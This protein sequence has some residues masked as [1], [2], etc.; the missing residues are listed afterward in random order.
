VKLPAPRI[1]SQFSL[2]KAIKQRRSVRGYADTSLILA[3]LSQLL[4]AAQGITSEAG[5]RAAPSAGAT[6]P[7]EVYAVVGAVAGL[8]A[9]SYRYGCKNHE[10]APVNVGDQRRALSA[11]A[12]GQ[13]MIEDAPL[14]L[15]LTAIYSRTSR[16]YG[17]RASRYVAMEAE[18]ISEN[19]YLQAA[20]LGLGTVAAGAFDDLEVARVLGADKEEAPLYL[21]P[22]GKLI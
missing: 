13:S 14:T 5:L 15:A 12:T 8:E 18:H 16:R 20:A 9:G 6:Y 10:L 21:M 2:E 7:F 17:E 22:V 19:I 11:A 1:D 3:D 4:W